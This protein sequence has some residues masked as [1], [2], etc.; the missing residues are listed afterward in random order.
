MCTVQGEHL[1]SETLFTFIN[2]HDVRCV[3]ALGTR[4]HSPPTA[5]TSAVPVVPLWTLDTHSCGCPETLDGGVTK[6]WHAAKHSARRAVPQLVALLFCR[7]E[8]QLV[9]NSPMRWL[10]P[11]VTDAM[12]VP[13]CANCIQ[14]VLDILHKRIAATP[15]I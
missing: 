11:I 6:S 3:V 15:N 2:C 7:E 9:R 12:S 10:L 8:K 5:R 4:P 13:I 1:C 14:L